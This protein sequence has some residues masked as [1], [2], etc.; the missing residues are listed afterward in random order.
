MREV[1]SVQWGLGTRLACAYPG[2]GY[3]GGG[4]GGTGGVRRG[5]KKGGRKGGKKLQGRGEAN[6][7]GGAQEGG[8][9]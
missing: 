5:G 2:G 4:H 9:K 7:R 8:E 3:G 1:L 6:T